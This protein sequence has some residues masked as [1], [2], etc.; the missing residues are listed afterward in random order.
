VDAQIK[1]SVVASDIFGVSGRAMLAALLAGERDPKRLAQLARTRLRAKLGPLVE[2]FTGFFTDQHAFLLAKLLARVDALDADL[3]ELVTKLAEL[4]APFTDAVDRWTSPWARPD[5]RMPAHR[6][7][8]NGHGPGSRPLG[9]WCR[10]PSSPPA[11]ASPPANARAAGRPGT[12]TRSWLGCSARPPSPPA[13]PI[14]SLVNATGGSPADAAR[15][16]PS[17]R[18]AG[19]SWSSSGTCCPTQRPTSVTSAPACYDTR[20]G[21]E[22]AKRNHIRQLEA[23]GYKVTLQPAA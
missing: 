16:A 23:L 5:R 7:A 18:S 22:R 19:P 12:A 1:L 4:I 10:G 3:A 2:A 17:W 9:I 13:R 11:S 6:R 14:P 21:P 20:I 15:G 8:G